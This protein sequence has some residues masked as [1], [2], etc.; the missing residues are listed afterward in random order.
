M[1]RDSRSHM[2]CSLPFF[3]TL[4]P[5]IRHADQMALLRTAAREKFDSSL[6][7]LRVSP[8]VGKQMEGAIQVRP[9]RRCVY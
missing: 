7:G 2:G 9:T 3:F 8:E 5:V 4:L 1:R 6:S